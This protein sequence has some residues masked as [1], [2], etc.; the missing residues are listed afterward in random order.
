MENHYTYVI[1]FSSCRNKMLVRACVLRIV[2]IKYNKIM[3]YIKES[4]NL[5][6]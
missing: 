1:Y 6:M 4:Y 5:Y 2:K 3:A